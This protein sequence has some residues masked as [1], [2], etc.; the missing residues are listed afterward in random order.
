MVV[1]NIRFH[2][3]HSSDSHTGRRG[4]TDMTKLIGAFRDYRNATKNEFCTSQRTLH[5]L[6]QI[7]E[8]C[9]VALYYE[10][11]ADYVNTALKMHSF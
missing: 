10:G 1:L 2:C 5:S 6:G 7:S 11:Y 9:T 3:S 8:Y 4:Q